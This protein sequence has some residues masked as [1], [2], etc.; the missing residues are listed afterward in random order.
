MSDISILQPQVIIFYAVATCALLE[1][2]AGPVFSLFGIDLM[3]PRVIMGM[4]LL[5]YLIYS[6]LSGGGAKGPSLSLEAVSGA[7]NTDARLSV[8]RDGWLS[9][10]LLTL[11]H[12]S[13]HRL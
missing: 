5:A 8:N 12:V 11:C 4:C 13:F 10:Q 2:K 9:H 1:V 7:H 3:D 6:Q